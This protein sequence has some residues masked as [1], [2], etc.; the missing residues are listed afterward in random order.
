VFVK[1]SL[2]SNP[3]TPHVSAS[4]R[5]IAEIS[6]NPNDSSKTLYQYTPLSYVV[7]CVKELVTSKTYSESPKAATKRTFGSPK[8]S[9]PPT[10]TYSDYPLQFYKSCSVVIDP[11]YV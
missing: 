10:K 1:G 7:A 4:F 6:A 8:E 2:L 3:G 5:R 9:N 11:Y